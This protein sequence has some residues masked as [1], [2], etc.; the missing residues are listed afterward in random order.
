M[1]FGGKKPETA[2]ETIDISD[3][4]SSASNVSLAPSTPASSVSLSN[5]DKVVNPAQ[6]FMY[7]HPGPHV[8]FDFRQEYIS[9]FDRRMRNPAY[10]IEHITPQS[11]AKNGA[12]DR[13]KSVFKENEAIPLKFRAKLADYFRSGYDRGHMAP[14]ANAK[15]SQDAM[16][17]TFYLTNMA[18]QVGDGFNRDYWA[19]FEDFCRRLT[20][21][22][23]SVRIVTGPLYLPK[24]HPDGKYRVTYE[25]IGNP[26]NI[27]VPTHFYKLIL[28][29]S[30]AKDPSSSDVAVGA[31]IMPN[32][33]IRNDTALKSFYV[34]VDAI[35]RSAGLDFLANLPM[36]RRKDLCR[37]VKCEIVVREF[38]KALPAPAQPLGLPA[39]RS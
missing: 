23:N 36:N 39:P 4:S 12:V 37:E 18:P 28:A 17:E 27:A 35:E 25:V 21:S 26:P 29:E 7:G 20:Q 30:P 13:K 6:F 32:D 33:V 9:A 11:I 19:H 8:D 5:P 24:R 14:A 16:D 1:G 15:F 10:V 31:F 3:S 34:P 2:T 38:I 22:Y